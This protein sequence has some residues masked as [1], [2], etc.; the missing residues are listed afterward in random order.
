[1]SR[2]NNDLRHLIPFYDVLCEE[3]L[4]G[5]Q[6]RLPFRLPRSGAHPHPLE[7]ACQCSLALLI[8]LPL[9]TQPLFLLFKPGGVVP[10]PWD[11]MAAIQLQNP[12]GDIV[13]E[14]TIVCNRNDRAGEIF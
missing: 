4:V 12:S 10:F 7:L 14:V 11:T 13:E 8:A 1:L 2:R 3:F 5:R 6:T 9:L